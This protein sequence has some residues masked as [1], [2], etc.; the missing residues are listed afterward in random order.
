MSIKIKTKDG[1]PY[2]QDKKRRLLVT[3][4][5]ENK[6]VKWLWV[7]TANDSIDFDGHTY[8]LIAE[9]MYKNDDNVLQI[10]FYEGISTPLSHK[11]IV[12]D[13]VEKEVL[14]N[15][16]KIKMKITKIKGLVY[17][18]KIV[19]IITNRKLA[20]NLT[21]LGNHDGLIPI[22][23]IVSIVNAILTAV[24]IIISYLAWNI[25]NSGV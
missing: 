6:S 19:N 9:G 1:Y 3:I 13:D 17:D 16:K 8:F 7:D 14:L 12:K 10:D 5:K 20:E 2:I 23:F 15:G 18:S 22:L 24:S 11:N 21:R 25:L 4:K